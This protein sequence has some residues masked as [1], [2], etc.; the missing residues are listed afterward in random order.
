MAGANGLKHGSNSLLNLSSAAT[1]VLAADRVDGDPNG[2]GV[3]DVGSGQQGSRGNEQLVPCNADRL[4][5]AIVRANASGGASLRLT[6]RCVYTLTAAQGPD[7]LP[8][9]TQPI[10]LDGQGATIARAAGAANFRIL[11]VG[12]GGN[13]TVEDL[14][15]AG[16][17]A[18]N[19]AG[20]GGIL[21]QSGGQATLR[22]A[23]VA[24]NQ[25]TSVGGG[26]ANY[27]ITTILGQDDGSG[28]G[29]WG[30]S[31]A[32]NKASGNGP[33]QAPPGGQSGGSATNSDA[34]QAIS[35]VDNNSTTDSGGGIFNDGRLS[36]DNVEISYNHS[37][38]FGGGLTDI[39]NAVLKRARIDHNTAAAGDVLGAS[40]GG[41]ASGSGVTKLED[42]SVSDNTA[43]RDG[44]GI[45]CEAATISLQNTKVD[46]NTATGDGGGIDTEPSPL[47]GGGSCIAVIEDSEVSGNTA[48]GSGGGISNRVSSLVLRRS[49]VS[50]NRAIGTA[51]QAGGIVNGNG[52]VTLTATQVTGNSSTVAP[53]GLATNRDAV[54]VDQKSAIVGNRP[55]NCA[56]STVT[57]P[58]C[59]G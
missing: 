10:S 59:F 14:T 40:G 44:G 35:K 52:A 38:G 27:G 33:T 3:Q 15:V 8:V 6:A 47:I 31:G 45:A 30:N 12:V 26:I 42:S 22:N 4:I 7:G 17:F 56:G 21:V 18:P 11:N 19:S 25:S 29:T 39:G 20:G 32:P 5:A 2:N 13:L 49:R 37:G 16:G 43:A 50:L 58:N 55:T 28:T 46:R 54:T 51:S 34:G 41:I 24:G 36:A 57:V 9:I 53:G 23:T 1:Q 48:S